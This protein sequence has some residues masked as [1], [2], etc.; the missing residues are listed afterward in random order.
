MRF[1][2]PQTWSVERGL[3]QHDIAIRSGEIIYL[4]MGGMIRAPVEIRTAEL[5]E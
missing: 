2:F 5:V 1:T 4:H 3:A